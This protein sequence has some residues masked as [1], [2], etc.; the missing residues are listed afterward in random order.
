MHRLGIVHGDLTLRNTLIDRDGAVRVGGFGSAHSA[1][2]A[3]VPD[4]RT[5]P[6]CRA[7]ER[8]AGVQDDAAPVDVW[9]IGVIMHCLFTLTCP[10]MIVERARDWFLALTLVLGPVTEAN[11]PGHAS[12]PKWAEVEEAAT[13]CLHTVVLP[14]N[15]PILGT[16]MR[17]SRAVVVVVVVVIVV[18]VVS[19]TSTSK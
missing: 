11:W 18:V 12:L 16:M 3:L 15:D 2:G 17:S 19:F 5:S 4:E 1:H 9:A 6:Y 14:G 7:P 8:W 10:W 13:S